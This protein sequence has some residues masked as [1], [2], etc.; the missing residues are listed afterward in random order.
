[1][2][3]METIR[4]RR[5]VRT[6]NGQALREEELQRITEAARKA[7]NP[8]GIPIEWKILEAGRSGLNSPV[9][10]GTELFIAGKMR[11][12]AHAEEAFGYAFEEIVLLAES[13]G[14]GTTWIAGTM[15]RSAFE[16]AMEL[17]EGEVMPCVSPLGYPAEKM[18]LRETMMRKG[19]RADSRIGFEKLF[20]EG[21]FDHP[22]SRDRAGVLQLPLDAVRLA[23]SAVNKQPW[24]AVTADG[25]VHFYEKMSRGFV[26][27]DGWDLQKI[28]LGI[29]LC[30]FEKT[31]AECGIATSFEIVD[32][33][34]PAEDGTRYIASFRVEG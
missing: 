16:S 8:Y 18:S 30:H 32:P 17:S 3:V 4:H 12:V 33:G 9:I 7:S 14:I 15:N 26:S 11:R 31:A 22:L 23:P 34:L 13:I 21:S 28:D 24:R 27:D 19:I 20:F 5:S 25:A 10:S 29:A 2:N 1:M 6:F